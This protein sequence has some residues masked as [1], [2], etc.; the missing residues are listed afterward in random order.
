MSV[1]RLVDLNERF[2]AEL[3]SETAAPVRRGRRIVR[4]SRDFIV[5]TLT[6]G[7]ELPRANVD[8]GI[9]PDSE[10]LGHF[11]D[12]QGNICLILS[13]AEWPELPKGAV[14]PTLM[15]SFTR[16]YP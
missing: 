4:V 16:I 1:E 5:G 3:R 11:D 13:S 15:V 8:Q 14:I 10:I 9:P 7:N 12:Q 6:T 2:A